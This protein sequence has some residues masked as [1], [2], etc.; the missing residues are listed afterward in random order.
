MVKNQ[1][2]A[3]FVLFCICCLLIGCD[4]SE[5]QY[6]VFTNEEEQAETSRLLNVVVE[7]VSNKDSEKIYSEFSEYTKNKY[8]VKEELDNAFAI[9]D[10]NVVE[11]QNKSAGIVGTSY[12]R[13][14]GETVLTYGGDLYGVKTD[15]GKSYTI[16]FYGTF[17][18]RWNPEY[19]GISSFWVS[20]DDVEPNS[21]EETESYHVGS[22][23]RH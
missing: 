16:S 21:E 5:R 17:F 1:R 23:G 14:Y 19:I 7:A 8:D 20:D 6:K 10:G 15:T 2:E 18:D 9:M 13:E 22:T 12:Y 4:K 3:I 11:I